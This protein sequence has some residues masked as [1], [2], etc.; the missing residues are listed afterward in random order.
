MG[1]TF[2]HAYLIMCHNNFK[3]LI[4]LLMALD[5]SRND[6][7]IHVDKK[8]TNCPFE[9]IQNSVRQAKLFW[10][11]RCSVNWGAASQIH[12]E[13]ILLK[14]ATESYHSYYHLLSGVDYPLKSQ[15]YIHDFFRKH[16]GSEFIQFDE[17]AIKAGNFQDR[18]RYYYF[19]QDIIGRNKGKLPALCYYIQRF[20]LSLQKRLHLDRIKKY[21]FSF[22]KGAQ[23]FS[24]THNLAE[25]L[26]QHEKDIRRIFKY[27]FCTDEIFLQTF[28]M[29]SPYKNNVVNDY[30][31]YI[32]WKRGN[33]YTFTEADYDELCKSDKLFARKF[34]EENSGKVVDQIHDNLLF[35]QCE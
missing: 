22:Y 11:K 32:D 7:Y 29:Q 4:K 25:Y 13:L 30:L 31:R 28:A 20:L 34:D 35:P 8:T 27:S 18:I 19:F 12:A 26:L 15:D 1:K 6:I 3:H 9:L 16:N 10:V 33:P 21:T 5:D 24:I 14:K 17:Y 2:K 23:W